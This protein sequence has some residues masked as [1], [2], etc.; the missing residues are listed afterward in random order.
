MPDKR[1]Y[2]DEDRANALAIWT[3]SGAAAAST[4]TG[5]PAGTIACWASR[6]GLQ[7]FGPERTR[8]AVEALQHQADQTWAEKRAELV[9]KLAGF[10]DAALEAALDSLEDGNL[11]MAKEGM[12]AVAIAVDK[13]QL[14]TGGATGRHENETSVTVKQTMAEAGRARVMELRPAPRELG[15]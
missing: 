7:R 13:T 5:I 15:A 12:L 3:D 1:V 4:I 2:T 11:R 14:L 6:R 10:A 9:H 8:A